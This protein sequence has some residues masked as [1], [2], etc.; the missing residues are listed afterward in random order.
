[1][2]FDLSRLLEGRELSFIFYGFS[3][4]HDLSISILLCKKNWPTLL[5]VISF[6]KTF[7]NSQ[8]GEGKYSFIQ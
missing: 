1:M 8:A 6:R 3:Q 5:G 4:S 7:M 2:P